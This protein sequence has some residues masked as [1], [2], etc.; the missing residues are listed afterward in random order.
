MSIHDL[1]ILF[2]TVQNTGVI[3]GTVPDNIETPLVIIVLHK[4]V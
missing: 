2:T 4:S 3:A 1:T